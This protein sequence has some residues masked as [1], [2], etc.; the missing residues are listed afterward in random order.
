MIITQ[1][2]IKKISK[3]LTKLAPNNEQKLATSINSILTYV[4]LLNEVDTHNISP[5][6]S[7]ISNNS[8]GFKHD[9]EKRNI[10]PTSLL[11]CSSQKIIANQIAVSDIMK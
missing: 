9:R 1:E 7:V 10:E 11:K 5:T 3:N 8:T 2:Q 6:I 4:D